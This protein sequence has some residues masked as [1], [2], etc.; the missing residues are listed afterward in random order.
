[1]ADTPP[2]LLLGRLALERGLVRREQLDLCLSDQEEAERLSVT[3]LPLGSLLVARGFLSV[4]DLAALLMEQAERAD[5]ATALEGVRRRD[6]LFG[7][8]AILRGL[9]SESQ[10]NMLLRMQARM[11]EDTGLPV[12]LGELLLL[13]GYA[14]PDDVARILDVQ[15]RVHWVCVACGVRAPEEKDDAGARPERAMRCPACGGELRLD[16]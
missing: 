3:R 16:A 6:Q 2:D 13:K 8:I 15:A 11:Q 12:R 4:T 10:L 14:Q 9:L 7:R 1:M 5:A